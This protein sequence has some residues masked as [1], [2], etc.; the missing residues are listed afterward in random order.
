MLIYLG[1]VEG[2]G[3]FQCVGRIIFGEKIPD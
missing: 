2:Q 1:R 3:Y